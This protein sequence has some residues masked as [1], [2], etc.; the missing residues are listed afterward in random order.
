MLLMSYSG[1]GVPD[2][3]RD[4][5]TDPA[6]TRVAEAKFWQAHY[7]VGI[8]NLK[9]HVRGTEENLL[10][11]RERLTSL[12]RNRLS[13]GYG[14]GGQKWEVSVQFIVEHAAAYG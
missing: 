9:L 3:I 11:L 12:V 6:V 7:G 5:E 10:K 8:A 14:T 13:G 1:K 4:V 2:V